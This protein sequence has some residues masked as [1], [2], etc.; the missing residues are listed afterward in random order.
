MSKRTRRSRAFVAELALLTVLAAAIAGAAEDVFTVTQVIPADGSSQ[1]ETDAT[2]LVTFSQ[3]VVPLTAISDPAAADLSNPLRLL[4]DVDGVGEWLNTSTFT[5][6]PSEPLAGG[7]VYTATVSAGLTDVEGDVLSE[8]VSWSFTTVRPRVLW[9]DPDRH[10]DRVPVDAE[11]RISFNMPIDSESVAGRLTVRTACLLGELFAKEVAGDIDVAGSVLT[12]TPERPLAFDQRYVVELDAGATGSAGGLGT[13]TSTRWEF[14]TVPLPRIVETDPRDGDRDAYPYTSFVIY[15]NTRIDPETV[16]ENV[17][18]EPEPDP[19]SLDGWYRFWDDAYVIRFGSRPSSAY[20]FRIGPHI[21]DPFGNETGQTLIVSFETGPLSPIAWLHVPGRT[22]TLSANEP[23]RLIVGHRNTDELDLRLWRLDLDDYFEATSD[24]YDYDPKGRPNRSWSV[25]VD[26]PLDE[27]VY[28]PVALTEEE[29]PLDPG[30]YIV[31]LRAKGVD[32]DR[33]DHRHLLV[34]SSANLTLKSTESEIL[35]WATDLDSGA[36]IPGLVLWAYDGDGKTI[37]A[38]VTDSHGLALL[39][40]TSEADW[41]HLTIVGRDPFVLADEGWD[42]GISIWDLDLPSETPPDAR[43]HLDTDRPIYRPEQTVFFRGILRDEEDATYTLPELRSVDV[44]I[45]NPEWDLVYEE[46]LTLD[47]FGVFSGSLDLPAD[48]PLG[49]YSLQARADD[50]TFYHDFQVA[51]YRAP[52]FEVEVMTQDPETV[53]DVAVPT[54]VEATYFFGAPLAGAPVEWNVLSEAYTF[55]PPAFGRYTFR[56]VDDPWIC[57][58]CWWMPPTPPIPILSG[59][60]ETDETGHL[61]FELP[62]DVASLSSDPDADPVTGSRRL[63]IEATVDG[64][65]GEAVSGRTDVVIHQARFYVGLAAGRSIGRAGEVSSVDVLTVDWAAQRVGQIP[66]R[67]T[68]FRREWTNVFEEDE[69]GG[70]WTWTVEDIEVQSGSLTTDAAGEGV[71]TFTPPEGGVYKISVEGEDSEGR[72]T[73][74]SLFLW[75]SGP[76]SVSW[77]RTNDDTIQLISDRTSYAVGETAEILVPSPFSGE[78]WAL[79]TVE[80]GGLLAREVVLLPSNSSVIRVPITEEHVPNV[81]VGVVLI[82]GREAA[83]AAAE[84]GPATAETKIGYLPL[85]V[86][87]AP[88]EL[89]IELLPSADRLEPGR[90][91]AIDLHVTD[92]Y[93][94]PVQA[95]FALDV[96]DKAVLSL[97]PRLEG[98]ILSTFY[99]RRGLGVRTASGLS[100]SLSRLLLEQLE[101]LDLLDEEKYAVDGVVGGAEPMMAAAPMEEAAEARTGDASAEGLLPPDVSVREDFLDT[102]FWHPNVLTDEEGLARVEVLLPDNLTTWIVRA[103]GAS[104]DTMVGEALAEVL[105]TKPLLIRPTTPRFF[106]VGDHVRL[107]AS[108]SNQTD[109]DLTVE[110]TLGSTGIDLEDPAVQ[111]VSVPAGAE[112]LVSWWATVPDVESVD[113]AFS[114]VSGELSDAAKPRLTLGPDGTLPV[115]RYTARETVG[116]AGQLDEE[117]RRVEAFV[118]PE[119]FDPDA[120]ELALRLDPSLAAAMTE[121]LSYLEHFEYECTEQLVSRFLPNALTYRALE[122]LGIEDPD[123]ATRLGELV[124]EALDELGARQNGD[125][126]WGWWKGER[127]SVHLTAY[128]AFALLRLAD[129]DVAVDA[130]MLERA[131]DYLEEGLLP[132]R[133]IESPWDANR[134]AWLAYVLALGGR[135]AAS[136]AIE[137]LVEDHERLSH[138]GVALL[139][140]A[141]AEAGGS[142]AALSTLVSDLVNDAILSATGAH[143]EEA[144][145][146]WWAMNTDTRSTAIILAALIRI[147]PENALLPNVV[148]WLMVAREAGIWETTQENAWALIALTDW[149]VLTGELRGNYELRAGLDE[150][151]VLVDVVTPGTVRVPREVRIPG[152]ELV[153]LDSHTLSIE[154]GPG[155]GTLYYTAHWTVGLPVAEVEPLDRGI[156]IERRYVPVGAAEGEDQDEPIDEVAT[157]SAGEMI[158]VRLT[159]TAPNDLYYIVVEDPIPAGCEAVDTSLATT[160]LLEPEPGLDRVDDRWPW[161][162]WWRWFSRSEFRDEKVVLFADFLSA[163]TYTYTY[164]LRAMTPGFFHVLP[165]SA[166]EFYFPEV[167]G[168]SD[169][170]LLKILEEE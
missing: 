66:L 38:S 104:A 153:D 78:Q 99:D 15:F 79:V 117:G 128:A 62:P 123:L 90:S 59:E 40:E 118:L 41:R 132:R 37:D 129:I 121:G 169:G 92:T 4:P 133:E 130:D 158:E 155:D 26:A 137:A 51:A 77:R 154:R 82:R 81:Y 18:I 80:R 69:T 150:T 72:T 95:S 86:D 115:L 84:G 114:A 160:S 156:S 109:R 119:S 68:A 67:F 144:A 24:W 53:R 64:P 73:R 145:V 32:H 124:P 33:W 48:A 76:D 93:G 134:N 147:D 85:S 138:Y 45:R 27:P 19:A 143:W 116:T 63:T 36:P 39:D 35:A 83:L 10:D 146:D 161:G 65:S 96:V 157:L 55:S 100:V 22:S 11:I 105:V 6:R 1:V 136:D 107:A 113:L 16:M 50:R 111:R 9:V 52:E 142:D 110:V 166:A 126:G 149:M 8:D 120:S 12:F 61:L 152:V 29:G 58:W 2:L 168:R 14:R 94:Y 5:F 31:D 103:T 54:A 140:L 13:E 89:Q 57:W 139:A 162:W 46:T 7:T 3:P 49:D 21:A 135:R 164:R 106:V 101:D 167:F 170:R 75:V 34:C 30:I 97:R 43:A 70:R 125:G 163:G 28:T 23:A 60:G 25:A 47:A 159:I 141:A 71:V 44:I 98:A 127:S 74:S 20:T 148:R 131:L 87:T 108:V 102:A 56:D 42:D 151:D 112:V 165:A 122:L 17:T 91:L 88:R